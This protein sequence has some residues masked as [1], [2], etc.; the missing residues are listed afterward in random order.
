MR[1]Y[2]LCTMSKVKALYHIVFCTKSRMNT[3]P[4]EHREDLYRFIW[5]E[6]VNQQC[7]LLRINGIQN[8]LH[9]LID[10]NPTVALATFMQ[11]IKGHS[12]LWLKRDS[13]FPHFV[14]WAAE[15][16]ACTIS[17]EQQNAVIEYIKSQPEHHNAVAFDDEIVGMYAFADLPYDDR[18]MK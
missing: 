1:N 2:Y 11:N 14:G 8:H 10:L 4:M 12:S 6:I 7:R 15:Y 9:L 18:D 5:K 13:R 3:I 17:P 16:Y